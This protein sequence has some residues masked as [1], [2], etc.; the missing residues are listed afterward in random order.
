ME[1]N[2]DSAVRLTEALLPILRRSAPSAIVNVSS[3]AARISRPGTGSYSAAKA[4]I[5]AWSDSLH[6][7]ER[8]H[9]VHVATVLPGFVATEG[10][11]QTQLTGR[12]LTRWMVGKP[13]Q[14]AGAIVA[15][16]GGKVEVAVPRWY[17]VLPRLRSTA[18]ALVRRSLRR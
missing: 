12:A 5:A 13:E 6:L 15:A 1:L 16:A 17:G 9:G 7:E 2:F 10:F 3:I 11:P 14:V 8:S 4:A 18:P